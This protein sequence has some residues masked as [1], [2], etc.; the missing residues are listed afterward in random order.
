MKKQILASLAFAAVLWQPI[1]QAYPDAPYSIAIHDSTGKKA[2]MITATASPLIGAVMVRMAQNALK[3]YFPK[4]AAAIQ[5]VSFALPKTFVQA[6]ASLNPYRIALVS[7]MLGAW[8]AYFFWYQITASKQVKRARALKEFSGLS[9]KLEH[10]RNDVNEILKVL[11]LKDKPTEYSIR[12]AGHEILTIKNEIAT[13]VTAL[14]S[15]TKIDPTVQAELDEF[16]RLCNNLATKLTSF[17]V[18]LDGFKQ[19]SKN[20]IVPLAHSP[21][22][23]TTYFQKNEMG[24]YKKFKKYIDTP[25]LKPLLVGIEAIEYFAKMITNPNIL[26]LVTATYFTPEII[27]VTTLTIKTCIQLLCGSPA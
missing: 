24:L 1:A 26:G 6:I 23:D 7:T 2:G 5:K 21:M 27:G 25:Q 13:A 9:T 18:T 10:A 22:G 17:H 19:K 12:K 15:A 14:K 8:M 11:N 20:G 16:D 4:D 3:M